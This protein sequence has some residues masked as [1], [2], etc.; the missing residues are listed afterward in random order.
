MGVLHLCST[1]WSRSFIIYQYCKNSQSTIIVLYIQVNKN[2]SLS[3][4]KFQSPVNK[5]I[6]H[7]QDSFSYISK[8]NTFFLKYLLLINFLIKKERQLLNT[9]CAYQCPSKRKAY[10]NNI[11]FF[12]SLHRMK[13]SLY[14]K[15]ITYFL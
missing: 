3:V 13:W 8:L 12:S 10:K 4:E 5:T 7:L 6:W 9:S 2:I 11:F 1:T 15:T 14:L